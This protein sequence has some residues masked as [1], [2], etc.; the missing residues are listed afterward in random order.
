M[1]HRTRN[2]ATIGAALALGVFATVLS[3]PATATAS[4]YQYTHIELSNDCWPNGDD[5]IIMTDYTD[6]P[7][8]E[9]IMYA[10]DAWIQAQSAERLC[11][12]ALWWVWL[13]S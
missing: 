8:P 3:E 5:C 9:R 1:R 13:P 2:L 7:C 12:Q 10:T 11:E 4:P 6:G